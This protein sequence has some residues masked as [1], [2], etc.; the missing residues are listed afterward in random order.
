MSHSRRSHAGLVEFDEV[1][2]RCSTFTP[3]DHAHKTDANENIHEF[4]MKTWGLH[5]NREILAKLVPASQP[6][7][8]EQLNLP[9]LRKRLGLRTQK[10][11]QRFK[12]CFR[13]VIL[14]AFGV[15]FSSF[16]GSA[17]GEK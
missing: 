10:P 11:S 8:S 2:H 13:D 16:D 9:A 1:G 3:I 5:A 15:G 12:H 14:D 4:E 6:I 7:I 17:H